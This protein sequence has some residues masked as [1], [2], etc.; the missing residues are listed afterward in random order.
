MGDTIY[1]IYQ[2]CNVYICKCIFVFQYLQASCK[3]L[4]ILWSSQKIFPENQEPAGMESKTTISSDIGYI[5]IN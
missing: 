4:R 2:S 5:S 3:G 1:I